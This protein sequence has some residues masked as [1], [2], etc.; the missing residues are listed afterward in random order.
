MKKKNLIITKIAKIYSA[1][2][3]ILTRCRTPMYTKHGTA[4]DY[5]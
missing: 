4:A 1:L 3:L 2:C 5:E